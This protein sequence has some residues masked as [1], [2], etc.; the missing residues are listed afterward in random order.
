MPSPF[1]IEKAAKIAALQ[2]ALNIT[3]GRRVLNRTAGYLAAV[4]EIELFLRASLERL[5]N[6]EPMESLAYAQDD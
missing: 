5:E 3:T 2:Y 4:D 1:E 6:N